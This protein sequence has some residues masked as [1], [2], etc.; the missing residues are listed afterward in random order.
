MMIRFFLESSTP[1]GTVVIGNVFPLIAASDNLGPK[2]HNIRRS[3]PS[4]LMPFC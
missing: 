4:V 2:A 3:R 1:G